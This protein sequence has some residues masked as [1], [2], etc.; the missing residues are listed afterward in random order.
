MENDENR[1]LS[2][3]LEDYLEAIFT[4]SAKR[5]FARSKDIADCLEV[6]RASVTGA[7]RQLSEKDLI[8]YKP[9][10]YVTLTEAGERI[11]ARV[12]H[13]H[14]TLNIFFRDILGLNEEISQRAACR[15]EHALDPEIIQRLILLSEFLDRKTRSGNNLAEEF[16]EFCRRQ[17]SDE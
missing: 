5:N 13:Q 4:L 16:L 2:A 9:Y 15:A 11:A 14:E 17:P 8:N 6:S 1:Q 12:N 7:L 3:S 10:G